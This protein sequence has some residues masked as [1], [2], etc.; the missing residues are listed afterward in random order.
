MVQNIAYKNYSTYQFE[1]LVLS[2]ERLWEHFIQMGKK[3]DG[4]ICSNIFTSWE[5]SKNY[6]VDPFQHYVP[7]ILNKNNLKARQ[8][9]NKIILSLANPVI[10][11]F[12]QMVKGSQTI[13]TVSD[14]EGVLL[15]MTGDKE[16]RNL[17]NKINFSPGAQWDEEI[18]G[19]NAI[20]T[21]I[22]QKTP[23][24]ILYT[25]HFCTGWHN[26][27]CVASPIMNPITNELVGVLDISGMWRNLPHHILG[28]AH[29]ISR[30]ISLEIEKNY[31]NEMLMINPL[32]VAAFSSVDDG[33]IIVDKNKRVV[34]VNN[35]TKEFLG[36]INPYD[37]HNYPKINNLIELILT[38]K[39]SF[40]ESELT[41]NNKRYYCKMNPVFDE[42]NNVT[43]AIACIRN[44]IYVPQTKKAVP[45][46]DDNPVRYNF[47]S[48]I[49]SSQTF[50]RCV[51][52]AKKAAKF[53][54]TILITGETGVGKELFA[55]A[56]HSESCRRN[57]PF[58]AINCGAIP[59]DLIESELFGYEPGAFTGA[60]QKGSPGKFELANGGTI[61]LDEIGEMPLT[62]Q[63][64]LLRVLEE[65]FV[66]RI[67]GSKNIPIDVRIIAATNRNLVEMA[68]EDSFRSDL[69]YRLK[70]IH[71][72][73][74]PLRE[75]KEDIPILTGKFAEQ[76]GHKFDIQG[77]KIDEMTLKLLR[78][79]SWPG[80]IRELKNT[81]EQALFNSDGN[82]LL[83]ADLPDEITNNKAKIDPE[84][85]EITKALI[86]SQFEINQAAN[87]LGVSRATLYRKMD[88]LNISVKKIKKMINS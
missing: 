3:P 52:K 46:N 77:I 62:V 72:E 66:T 54:S 56:I 81:I 25:E 9:Q 35:K 83:P 63:V 18:A 26:W 23:I 31:L 28:M 13:I 47:T 53:D 34:K 38:R 6:G 60:K 40:I 58:V 4:P 2:I 21:V 20:G 65:R 76:I 17:A 75:R 44:D 12:D 41:F 61:F 45:I 36:V 15:D 80:N 30:T 51:N 50:L 42:H 88:K 37:I 85:E 43:G 69:L 27:T 57:K 5:R 7:K 68:A 86:N 1:E 74:P 16:I 79:Y 70:V 24:Q 49:G 59:K 64:H 19:T 32:L 73:V 39:E 84:K 71:L 14:V 82:I 8:E 78:N 48:M 87:L 55:Q 10:K 33:V 29:S 22:E 11:Q 67:G